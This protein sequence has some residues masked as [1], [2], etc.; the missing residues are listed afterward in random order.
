MG[1]SEAGFTLIE[2]MQALVLAAI[3]LAG[4]FTLMLST[5]HANTSARDLTQAAT[6]AEAK[7]EEMRT[8]SFAS[9]AGGA[10]QVA[11]GNLTVPRSWTVASGPT[12]GTRTVVVRVQPPRLPPVELRTLISAP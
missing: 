11:I 5:I 3:S 12:A 1:R 9:L 2:V 4:A 8:A 7:L 10:D 6:A